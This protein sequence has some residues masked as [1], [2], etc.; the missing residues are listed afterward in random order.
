[1]SIYPNPV[2]GDAYLNV[3]LDANAQVMIY[4]SNMNG[5]I[6]LRQDAGILAAGTHKAIALNTAGLPNG[7]YMAT[8][9]MGNKTL[10]QKV[11][12]IR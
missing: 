9:Q 5:Q 11:N 4:L 8:V 3:A 6:V 2:V 7:L 10:H 12:L 1:M